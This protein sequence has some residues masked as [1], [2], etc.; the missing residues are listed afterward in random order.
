[1]D[2]LNGAVVEERSE[3]ACGF[4]SCSG[5]NDACTSFW[6]FM[7]VTARDSDLSHVKLLERTSLQ[8]LCRAV[9]SRAVCCSVKDFVRCGD[10][11]LPLCGA[12]VPLL[13]TSIQP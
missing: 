2:I 1:M 13:Y 10:Q 7:A 4:L 12:S 9:M 8:V 6:M 5:Y 3:A 11:R